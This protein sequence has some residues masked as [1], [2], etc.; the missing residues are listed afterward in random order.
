MEYDA[1]VLGSALWTAVTLERM[2]AIRG[3]LRAAECEGVA[4]RWL[5]VLSVGGAAITLSACVQLGFLTVNAAASFRRC[6]A[7]MEPGRIRATSSG[8]AAREPAA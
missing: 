4:T 1:A 2:T 7:L 8:T 6:G 5:R 3:A